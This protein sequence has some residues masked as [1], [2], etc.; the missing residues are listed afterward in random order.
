MTSN[1]TT[2]RFGVATQKQAPA[3][4]ST[5]GLRTWRGG[6]NGAG[7][8]VVFTV[9]TSR[10]VD[11][12]RREVILSACA[13]VSQNSSTVVLRTPPWGID[14]VFMVKTT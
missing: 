9:K 10:V 12:P 14:V 7:A 1:Q 3:R 13:S 8:H 6:M 2:G 4:G 5:V 11:G